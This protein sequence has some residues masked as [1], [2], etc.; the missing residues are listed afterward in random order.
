MT[1]AWAQ[2][3]KSLWAGAT[4][5]MLYLHQRQSMTLLVLRL[6]P[7]TT[8]SLRRRPLFKGFNILNSPLCVHTM[9]IYCNI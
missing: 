4:L 1:K 8:S 7:H 5:R 9:N 6:S 2:M 3:A